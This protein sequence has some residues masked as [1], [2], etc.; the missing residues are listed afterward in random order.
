MVYSKKGS[1][2]RP[3]SSSRYAG[4]PGLIHLRRQSSKTP[5]SPK[6]MRQY[7]PPVSTPRTMAYSDQVCKAPTGDLNRPSRPY[8]GC[9]KRHRPNGQ[10]PLFWLAVAVESL[11]TFFQNDHS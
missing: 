6:S 7:L 4:T 3:E 1:S 8:K 10:D 5:V 11:A 2:P 9:R